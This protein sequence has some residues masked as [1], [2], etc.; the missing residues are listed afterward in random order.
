MV[1]WA[2]GPLGRWSADP[3]KNVKTYVRRGIAVF[4]GAVDS[5]SIYMPEHVGNN[6]T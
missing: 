2:A 3:T 1:S 5:K 4:K 6:L